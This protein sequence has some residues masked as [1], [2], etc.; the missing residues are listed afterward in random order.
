[1]V[2]ENP[3]IAKLKTA[4]DKLAEVYESEVKDDKPDNGNLSI[5]NNAILSIEDCLKNMGG[6]P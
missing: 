3:S 5:I 6:Y 1:M 2:Q 4:R